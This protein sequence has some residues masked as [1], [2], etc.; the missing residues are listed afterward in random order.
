MVVGAVSPLVRALRWLDAG[1][2]GG[3]GDPAEGVAL[4]GA[5]GDRGA[6][7]GEAG[8]RVEVEARQELRHA[9]G[10]GVVAGRF[11]GE[12]GGRGVARPDVCPA[13]PRPR[14]DRAGPPRGERMDRQQRAFVHRPCPGGR[15]GAERSRSGEPAAGLRGRVRGDGPGRGRGEVRPDPTVRA[16]KIEPPGL[17]GAG[18]LDAVDLD[19]ER[20]LRSRPRL[21]RD[22]EGRSLGRGGH[23][24]PPA[25]E[26]RHRPYDVRPRQ[27]ALRHRVGFPHR[28]TVHPRHD[29]GVF[30]DAPRRLAVGGVVD[31]RRSRRT[32]SQVDDIPVGVDRRG[33]A[34]VPAHRGAEERRGQAGECRR[35]ARVAPRA[36]GH[37]GQTGC[38]GE[39]A[40][41]GGRE[42]PGGVTARGR[43]G[44]HGGDAITDGPAPGS[45]GSQHFHWIVSRRLDTGGARWLNCK[46][47]E[48][49]TTN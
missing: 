21:D 31:R 9:A 14:R 19:A 20:E 28:P 45:R 17:P 27:V 25:A 48:H 29:A 49:L 33:Q 42:E 7:F 3:G 15:T 24:H 11:E 12:R 46:T 16:E 47:V 38:D 10:V 43:G 35:R 2:A 39:R 41:K 44:S 36:A 34:A 18:A 5:A 8:G 1:G 4:G 13:V 26:P 30:R 6:G 37:Q 23:R 40:E 32:G 22:D